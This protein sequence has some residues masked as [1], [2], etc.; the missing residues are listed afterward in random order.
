MVKCLG[1]PI[2]ITKYNSIGWV[3]LIKHLK[4]HSSFNCTTFEKELG[5]FPHYCMGLSI[6]FSLALRHCEFSV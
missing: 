6:F 5:T 2:I 1:V 3:L 4:F